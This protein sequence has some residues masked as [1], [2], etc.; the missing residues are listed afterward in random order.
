MPGAA[1]SEGC[2]MWPIFAGQQFWIMTLFRIHRHI[3]PICLVGLKVASWDG[4]FDDVLLHW[5]DKNDVDK[6]MFVTVLMLQPQKAAVSPLYPLPCMSAPCNLSPNH[7]NEGSFIWKVGDEWRW[8]KDDGK[9]NTKC[10][11]CKLYWFCMCAFERTSTCSQQSHCQTLSRTV[12]WKLAR[13]I[14]WHPAS[15][16]SALSFSLGWEPRGSVWSTAKNTALLRILAFCL[17][18]P[19]WNESWRAQIVA[20]WKGNPPSKF[21]KTVAMSWWFCFGLPAAAWFIALR[22][23]YVGVKHWISPCQVRLCVKC[24]YKSQQS[25]T[26]CPNNCF[27]RNVFESVSFADHL[28]K[29]KKKNNFCAMRFSCFVSKP[30]EFGVGEKTSN[31]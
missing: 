14:N 31:P 9:E 24:L 3:E 18:K 16:T 29:S 21:D 17:D 8:I 6:C 23:L 27:I 10:I 30:L 2:I 26:M 12:S 25:I 1:G 7:C 22:Q 20:H 5:T 4:L 13:E 28:I 11:L 19:C 15:A